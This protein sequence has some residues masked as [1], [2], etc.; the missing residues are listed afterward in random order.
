MQK[1]RRHPDKSGLRPLVSV[2]FQSLFTP[3]LRVLFTFPLRYLCTI[4]RWVVFSLGRWSSRFPTGFLVPR[5]TQDTA[6]VRHTFAYG[7][8]TPYGRASHRVRLE[9]LVPTHAVL[10]PRAA[11]LPFGLGFSPFARHYSGNAIIVSFP[12][13]T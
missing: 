1:A 3:F 9:W 7:A 13:G 10:Q 12:A 6:S 8:L 4:G 5:G 2:W 11:S